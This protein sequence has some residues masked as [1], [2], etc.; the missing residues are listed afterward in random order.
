MGFFEYLSQIQAPKPTGILQIGA[1]IGQELQVFHENEIELAIL[2]EPQGEQY[3]KLVLEAQKYSMYIPINV[4][5]AET[6][7]EH[8]SLHVASNDGGSSSLLEPTGHKSAFPGVKFERKATMVGYTVDDLMSMLNNS[9][10]S[11]HPNR[12]D[13][14]YMDTQG[15]EYNILLGAT[16]TLKQIKYIYMEYMRPG[17]Y[18]NAR[19]LES[20][21]NLLDNLGFTLN[22]INFNLAHHS[23]ALFVRK[24]ILAIEH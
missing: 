20:Y 15:S 4:L 10:L 24:T 9:P 14:L 6:S 8:H 18:K 21:L 3:E 5:C 7:G 17:F 12:I 16:K 1:N 19:T 11:P 22:N 23:D 2:V 13:T